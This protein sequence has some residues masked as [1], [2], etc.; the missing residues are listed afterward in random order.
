METAGDQYTAGRGALTSHP[1][2]HDTVKD[3]G[4]TLILSDTTS[5]RLGADHAERTIWNTDPAPDPR[6]ASLEDV[7]ASHDNWS[8]FNFQPPVRA[9]SHRVG[10]G[11]V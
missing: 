11:Y 2:L 10:P 8:V 7:S 3:G 5:A 6:P 1:I 4:E 9:C